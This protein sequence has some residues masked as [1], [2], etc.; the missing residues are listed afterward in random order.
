MN[1]A[2]HPPQ[3]HS[4]HT[5]PAQQHGVLVLDKPKGPTSTACLERIKR[6]LGQK[7]IGHA[8]TLDPMASGV[9]LVMLG[10]ATKLAPY[11]TEGFKTYRGEMTLGVTTDT[12]DAE[13][14][15]VEEADW[16][17]LT[18]DDVHAAVLAWREDTTQTVPPYSA[19]KHKGKALYALARAGKDVPVKTKPVT[20]FGASVLHMDLPHVAFRV[21]CGAGVYIR[22]LVHSL[23]MRLG[24]GAHLTALTR[25]ESRPFTL[26]QAHPL[27]AVLD[28]PE[29]LPS[30]VIP[31]AQALPHWPRVT[32]DA[33]E[34]KL[35]KNGAQLPYAPPPAATRAAAALTE[36]EAPCAPAAVTQRALFVDQHGDA[37]ALA[38]HAVKDGQPVWA[39]LRGLWS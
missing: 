22:S 8:G 1:A 18:T 12:Y 38:Q 7:K 6:T 3:E 35:V 11:L 4:A 2:T 21:Q 15:V 23:G 32:L 9:L 14:A 5:R 39:L 26:A 25:E 36:E 24:C 16:R 27:D 10:Q 17:G 34:T 31:L 29:A 19:A 28:A 37:V 13:G 20:I 33:Q 30:R